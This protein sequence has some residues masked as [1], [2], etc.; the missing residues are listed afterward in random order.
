[1]PQNERAGILEGA[2][3]DGHG[4]GQEDEGHDPPEDE[5]G[6]QELL[7]VGAES[8][9]QTEDGQIIGLAAPMSSA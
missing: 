7:E 9:T 4:D 8:G 6:G 2:V 3:A 5:Q 1:M